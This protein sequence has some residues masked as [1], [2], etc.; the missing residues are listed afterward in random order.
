MQWEEG[1][2]DAE[3]E[4]ARERERES[5]SPKQERREW[6]IEDWVKG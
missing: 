1:I 2:G 6:G 5:E 3:T 4:R